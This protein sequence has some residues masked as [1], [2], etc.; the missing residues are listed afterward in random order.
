[1]KLLLIGS[2]GREH[3]LAWKLGKSEKVEKIFVAPGNGGTATHDKCENINITD[4]D[5]LIAFAKKEGIDIT[6]VGP[7]DP[8]TEGIVDEFKKENLKIFGPAK[9][10]AMLEGSKSFSKDFM[11]NYGVKTAE[12]ATFTNVNE[13][14][15]Y[16][17]NCTYPTVVKADGLAAG[18]G[19]IICENKEEAIEAV[20][21]CMVDD[22]F[23]GA[24]QKI[25]IEEFLEGV[26]ASILS[27][28]DGKTIIPFLS[29]KDH[30]QIFDDGKGPNTG[31]MGVLA[32]N[33]YV[34]EEVLSDFKEN[35]M[36]KTLVGIKEE[37]FDF[38][39][40]IFFGLMITKKGT[41]LLE[42][43]VRMG[44][45]ETQS[46]LY[47]MESDL[48]E[49][50]EAA[51]NEE[52]DKAQ[53]KWNKGICINVVLASNGYPNK[54]NKG[55]QINID[56]KVKDKVFLAGAKYEDGILKTSGGRVLS[57]IGC[58]ENVEEARKEAYLNIDKVT[59][60]G[61]YCRKD[62]GIYK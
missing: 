11:K 54:F 29:A 42:Y 49:V 57:V 16:L 19:V 55:Y 58:G 5:E 35:I 53:I 22:A 45:P 6:I 28:T 25:V 37:G 2:G 43:N 3:A 33:P 27:I 60:E 14:L 47:L 41:Y 56:E 12:Y 13:A 23:N 26:E 36:N 38:K 10:G 9:D 30:K 31:G 39:G 62:I 40:I 18:K 7:E 52:L 48:L 32:P 15:E 21:T 50:I 61:A 59:F 44:D 46:V 24:G 8:L 4:I 20:N 34:T 1:M 51:L 17:E